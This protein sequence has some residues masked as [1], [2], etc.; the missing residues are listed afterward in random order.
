MSKWGKGRT[1]LNT[2][3]IFSKDKKN[4]TNASAVMHKKKPQVFLNNNS[5]CEN[6]VEFAKT[7]PRHEETLK[8]FNWEKGQFR[9][10]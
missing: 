4:P 10:V 7:C 5:I 3:K 8:S 2:S 9:V 6:A 1:E